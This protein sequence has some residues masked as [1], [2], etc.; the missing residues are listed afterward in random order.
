VCAESAL[1]VDTGLVWRPAT[2]LLLTVTGSG[3]RN[4]LACS[5]LDASVTHTVSRAEDRAKLVVVV[6]AAGAGDGDGVSFDGE[7]PRG[8]RRGGT[9]GRGWIEDALRWLIWSWVIGTD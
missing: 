9:R 4:R 1:H 5:V 6:V 2:V 7:A 3:V 8:C